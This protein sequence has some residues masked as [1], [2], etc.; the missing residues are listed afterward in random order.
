MNIKQ[1]NQYYAH[2]A[3][4]AAKSKAEANM[5]NSVDQQRQQ[6]RYTA[7]V[8]RTPASNANYRLHFGYESIKDYRFN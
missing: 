4:A 8:K 1:L 5:R 7:K 2:R 3:S 6:H